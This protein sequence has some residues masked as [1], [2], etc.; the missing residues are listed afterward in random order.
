MRDR[1]AY[2]ALSDVSFCFWPATGPTSPQAIAVPTCVKPQPGLCDIDWGSAPG[3]WGPTVPWNFPVPQKARVLLRTRSGV[4]LLWAQPNRVDIAVDLPGHRP[5]DPGDPSARIL[6]WPHFNYLLY[7]AGTLARGQTPERFL[8]WKQS[9]LLGMGSPVLWLLL[10]VVLWSLCALWFVLGRRF[11]RE[12]AAA[13]WVSALTRP[14]QAGPDPAGQAANKPDAKPDTE[15]RLAWQRVGFARPLSGFLTLLGSMLL[16]IGPYYALQS[17]WA[18]SIQPFPEADGMWRNT[19]SMLFI[20]WLTFDMG[21]QTAVVKYFAE[22][23]ALKPEEALKDIQFYVFWQIAA[24]S[25]EATV[26][27]AVALRVIPWTTYVVYAPFV[28]LYALVQL[29]SIASVPK[30]LCQGL[31]RFDYQNLLD[32]A[33]TRVLCFLAPIPFILLGRSLGKGL[34]QYGEAFGAAIGMGIGSLFTQLCVFAIGVLALRKMRIPFLPILLPHFDWATAKRQLSF[35]FKVTLGQ[36]PFRLI[37]FLEGLIIMRW[38]HDYP[39]WLGIRDLLH[40]RITFLFV[41]AWS[42]YQSALSVIS[43]TVA[44]N[45]KALFRYYIARYLQF[46]FFFSA[47]VFSMLFAVGPRYIAVALGPQW[48]AASDYLLLGCLSG[49]LLP[50]AWLSDFLQQGAGKPGT[51]TIVMLIEQGLR[52]L[53]LLWFVQHLQFAGIY[54]A[55]IVALVVKCVVGWWLNHRNVIDHPFSGAKPRFFVFLP[56]LVGVFNFLLWRGL[57][58]LT[59]PTSWL[60]MILLFF[61]AGAGSFAFGFFALG[62]L[63]GLDGQVLRELD[64]AANMSS[65][66][67]PICVGIVRLAHLGAQRSPWPAP[68]FP[69]TE[70]TT[71]LQEAEGLFSN[72]FQTENR[73]TEN[74]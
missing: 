44:Q 3:H 26:L 17:F 5:P 23:R 35:G 59:L 67:R 60:G 48:R 30:L 14:V 29:P 6:Q 50:L 41:F 19:E 34:P 71:A 52:L 18:G 40:N 65:L 58:Q 11:H 24:R 9:P 46:G 64:Q 25:V 31:Q 4:P 7:T 8:A 56:L 27:F 68:E 61:L 21:T 70:T 54:V 51:T 36:E 47:L 42:Y 73:Q 49:L 38:L 37:S 72:Q 62:F 63:G 39:V 74:R 45:K 69:G 55:A 20:A 53:L 66:V 16:L 43:E 57:T 12:P 2:P 33:E 10:S 13:L 1:L 22:H 28:L 15:S 32:V